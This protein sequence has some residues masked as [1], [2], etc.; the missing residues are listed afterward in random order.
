MEI[1]FETIEFQKKE[2]NLLFC[3]EEG[4]GKSSMINFILKK[5]K[6][7]ISEMHTKTW[8][9]TKYTVNVNQLV[10]NLYDMPGIE[11]KYSDE[12]IARELQGYKFDIIIC[13]LDGT[14]I[15]PSG[16]IRKS[17]NFIFRYVP[18]TP[19]L[20]TITKENLLFQT[21]INRINE[22]KSSVREIANPLFKHF[23]LISV[24]NSI[25]FTKSHPFWTELIT[26]LPEMENVI[27][28]NF[29]NYQMDEDSIYQSVQEYI[30]DNYKTIPIVEQKIRIKEYRI[31]N[32]KLIFGIFAY[33]YV[34]LCTVTIISNVTCEFFHMAQAIAISF[35]A[36]LILLKIVIWMYST[37]K[38][39][40][41]PINVEDLETNVGKFTGVINYVSSDKFYTRLSGT[42]TFEGSVYTVDLHNETCCVFEFCDHNYFNKYSEVVNV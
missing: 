35:I 1:T 13:C 6:A 4:T 8:K 10:L 42:V 33:L 16:M 32:L 25:P 29:N 40:I 34:I 30:T 24:G 37:N 11:G 27:V 31:K 12:V 18:N 7:S 23:G 21:E 39:G 26:C 3:G 19:V 17:C 20:F 5:H 38:Y 2:L 9:L 36:V 14:R 22:I 41:F 28:Q 15:R